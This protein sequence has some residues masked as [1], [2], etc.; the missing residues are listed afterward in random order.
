MIAVFTMRWM[1]SAAMS[2]GPTTRLMGSVVRSCS[3]RA[4]SRSPSSDADNGVSTK[5]GAIRLTRMGAS[6]SA[7]DLVSAGV[8]AAERGDERARGRPSTADSADEQERSARAHFA[9]GETGDVER[10][11]ELLARRCAARG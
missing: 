2:A 6:S 1:A 3:R 7:S 4:S 8:A 11:P 10:Q 5:P 9:G